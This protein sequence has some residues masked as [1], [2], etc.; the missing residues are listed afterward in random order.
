MTGLKKQLEEHRGHHGHDDLAGQVERVQHREHAEDRDLERA[1]VNVSHAALERAQLRVV[2]DLV[3]GAAELVAGQAFHLAGG[4]F[5]LRLLRRLLLSHGSTPARGARGPRSACGHAEGE[6]VCVRAQFAVQRH[7]C[8]R[9]SLG[10]LASLD[11]LA[12]R[13]SE[14][15]CAARS[16]RYRRVRHGRNGAAAVWPGI[17]R[18]R[19]AGGARAPDP[20]HGGIDDAASQGPASLAGR[21]R[22][23]GGGRGHRVRQQRQHNPRAHGRRARRHIRSRV[24]TLGNSDPLT[25]PAATGTLVLHTSTY[26]VTLNFRR[27]RRRIAA[28]GP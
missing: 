19:G 12:Y 20:S 21:G 15:R 11:Y 23:D 22:G 13:D 2:H 6:S 5:A 24:A 25:P 8:A 7:S 28:R 26:S 9:V 3:V 1:R 27:V 4:R 10:A 14:P 16:V 18:G 17:L